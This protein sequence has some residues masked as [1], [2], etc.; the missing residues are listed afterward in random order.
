VDNVPQILSLMKL[1][2]PLQTTF[3]LLSIVFLGACSKSGS[4]NPKPQSNTPVLA[5]NSLSVTSGGYTTSVIITGTVFSSTIANDH[6]FFNGKAAT[7]TAATTTQLTATVPLGAGTGNVTV[8]VNNGAAVTGPVFTY[9]LS[10]VVTTFAGVAGFTDGKGTAATFTGPWGV[11]FDPSGNLFVTDGF[12]LRK[13]TPDGTV[14]FFAGNAS[15]NGPQKDGKGAGAAFDYP[16]SIAS[17][18]AGNLYIAD[19]QSIQ[20][21]TPDGTVTTVPGSYFSSAEFTGIVLDA[22]GNI[23]ASDSQDNAIIKINTNGTSS[24]F[25]GNG[26]KSSVDG[27]GT[28]A[29]FGNPEDLVL[30]AAGN[31]YVADGSTIR[32]ITFQ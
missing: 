6:V 31:I 9:Q 5:I 10:A 23:Y 20:K 22:S 21:V 7:I 26:T 13:I 15:G 24:T 1:S 14:S 32:K 3:I 25:A 11:A 12:L 17:D 27:I 4:N 2:I 8:S 16:T 30:D 28:A 18:A 29:V 19:N